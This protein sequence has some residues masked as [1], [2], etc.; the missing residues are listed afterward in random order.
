MEVE[1]PRD[2]PLVI[3]NHVDG[4][5]AVWIPAGRFAM[6]SKGGDRN[7]RPVHEAYTDSYYMD[8]RPV[9]NSMFAEFGRSSG[10]SLDWILP[11]GCEDH[12]VVDVNWHD[13]QAYCQWAEKR[14]PTEAEWEKAARGFDER[15]FPWGNSFA[16]ARV[17][18]LRNGFSGTSPT[19]NFPE[20]CSPF[21]I[22]DLAGNVWEWVADRYDP[23]RYSRRQPELAPDEVAGEDRVM[24]GGSWISHQR[25]LRCSKREHAPP[26]QRSR[27]VG[28]RCV[29]VGAS[30]ELRLS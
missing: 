11:E 26:D 5:V 20:G 14:L 4:G 1:V 27:F 18:I 9:T 16:A 15:A 17:S 22:L 21:G 3:R 23:D 24:R 2:I 7:E 28:F 29:T 12:P 10:Y 6:G 25:Y 19:G 30:T 13:A 8:L